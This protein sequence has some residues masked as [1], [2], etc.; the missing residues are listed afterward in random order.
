MKCDIDVIL[1]KM[2]VVLISSV[3]VLV[4]TDLIVSCNVHLTQCLDLL[5]PSQI[6]RTPNI[7]INFDNIFEN[8]ENLLILVLLGGEEKSVMHSHI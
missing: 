8:I 4:L 2:F 6:Y 1:S 7:N 5:S 3:I